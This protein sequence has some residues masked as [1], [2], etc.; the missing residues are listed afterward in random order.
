MQNLLIRLYKK[1]LNREDNPYSFTL[2]IAPNE[3]VTLTYGM[4]DN[5]EEIKSNTEKNIKKSYFCKK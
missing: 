5:F 4:G 3:A 1:R 2:N